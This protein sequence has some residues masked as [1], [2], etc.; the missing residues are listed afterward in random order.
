MALSILPMFALQAAR[1]ALVDPV[2]PVIFAVIALVATG[3]IGLGA[4]G[5]PVR[6]RPTMA[7]PGRSL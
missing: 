4:V 7:A 5:R 1:G 2:A 6:V 3:L